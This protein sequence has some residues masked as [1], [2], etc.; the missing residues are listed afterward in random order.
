MNQDLKP[1]VVREPETVA[2]RLEMLE[3]PELRSHVPAV[4]HVVVPLWP[5]QVTL[6]ELLRQ[7]SEQSRRGRRSPAKG[8]KPPTP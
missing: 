6:R 7:P 8:E 1:E 3:R 4:P 2:Q 5:R